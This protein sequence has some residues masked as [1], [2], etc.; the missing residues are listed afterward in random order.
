MISNG[1]LSE[2]NAG[3]V[4]TDGPQLITKLVR[5]IDETKEEK[6]KVFFIINLV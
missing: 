1:I 3:F 6:I 4:I 5:I 2:S